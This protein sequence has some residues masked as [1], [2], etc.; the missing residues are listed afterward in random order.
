MLIVDYAYFTIH[1]VVTDV[2]ARFRA[3]TFFD[4]I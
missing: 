2:Y 4:D 1:F 3:V